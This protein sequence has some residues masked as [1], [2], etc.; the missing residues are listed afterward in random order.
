METLISTTDFVLNQDT[1][2]TSARRLSQIIGY[3]DFLKKPLKLG[4]FVACDENDVPLDEPSKED[5]DWFN[6]QING[7]FS[8][9]YSF[10]FNWIEAKKKILFDL[11]ETS[12]EDGIIF[13]IFGKCII[14]FF[15]ICNE[16]ILSAEFTTI[17][18]LVEFDLI[19]TDTAKKEI[20]LI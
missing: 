12:H 14:G 13:Q 15:S 16:W 11:F 3:A 5:I 4:Y 9:R 17:E 10:V 19:L 7:D 1:K 20:G 8:E 18:D 2:Q 6:N